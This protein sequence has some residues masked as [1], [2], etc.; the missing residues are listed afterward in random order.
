VCATG[1]F[2][3]TVSV[4]RGAESGGQA[5]QAIS[6]LVSGNYFSVLGADP[7][8]GRP[9]TPDDTDAAGGRHVAVLSYRYWQQEMSADQTAIGQGITVNGTPFTVVGVMAPKFFGAE[10]NEES[11]DMWLPITSQPEVMLQP[12]QLNPHGLFWMHLM[13]R[14]RDGVSPEQSQAWATTKLQ[15]FMMA[16]EGAQVSEKRQ[17]EIGQIRIDMLPGGRGVSH[18]RA[19]FEQPL[20]ILMGVVGLVLAIACANLANFLLSKAA[21]REREFSTRLALGA[22]HGRIARQILTEALILSGIGGLLGLALAFWGTHVLVAF[23]VAGAK[24]TAIDA[25]PDFAVLAFTFGVSLLTGILFGIAP[26]LRTSRIGSAP[27]LSATARTAVGAGGRSGRLF[28]R[29]LLV[30]QVGLSLVLLVGAGL[31]VRTLQ[32]LKNED[33]GFNRH[34]V[35][36]LEVSAKLA[37]YKPEQLPGLYERIFNRLNALPGV[38]SVAL[39]GIPP[40][41]GGNWGALISMTGYSPA[42]DEDLSTSINGVSPEYFST[43]GI[44]LVSG[45][46][47]GKQDTESAT[48]VVVV[49]QSLANH[50]FPHGDAVGHQFTIG[51]PDV[52]GPWQI[53]G[54]VRDAKY[55]SP[56]EEPQRMI[57]LP[58]AQ[59][60]GNNRF[61]N[62]LEVRA[63]G[64][65]ANVASEVRTAMTEIDPSVPLLSVR[66][67]GEQVDLF[68][69][70]ER[71]ISQLSTFFALLALAL[72]CIGLYGVMAY[73]V[74]RRTNEIGVRMAL[75]AQNGSIL[76]M[77]LRESLMLLGIGVALGVPAALAATR[78]VQ[79]QR[80]G[81]KSSDPATFAAAAVLIAAVVVLAAYGPARRAAKVDP[82]VALRYE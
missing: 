9:L 25:N 40:I 45:R 75:G 1:S 69:E 54:V 38:T 32:N 33:L 76:W 56:R 44:P 17:K 77:V 48:R 80:F 41:Y 31:F 20:L 22:S 81:L 43:V 60:T 65:P 15:Q 16:R 74:T 39:S 30:A 14:L 70:N 61:A 58:L 78:L 47:I 18:L 50:F 66:T 6:H 19:Q 68:M 42:P 23:V 52:P 21:V 13:A 35:L 57:Y 36:L 34:N 4:R 63:V 2:P 11:P 62:A 3:I 82:M 59:L 10:L 27:A 28:P 49:N 7:I 79:A 51:E 71:L 29:I 5:R 64:D 72:A 53:I 73:N 26:S 46:S 55:N 37:G 67:I 12:S 24:N 8:L